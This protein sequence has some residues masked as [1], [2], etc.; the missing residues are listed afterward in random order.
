MYPATPSLTWP[1]KMYFGAQATCL[2]A[3]PCNKPFSAPDSDVLVCL[4]SLC[5]AYELALTLSSESYL[6]QNNKTIKTNL[7]PKLD[8][9]QYRPLWRVQLFLKANVINIAMGQNILL[10]I[11]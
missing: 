7:F 11:S 8:F 6:K 3:W 1:L 9:F 4:A 2:L 5:Q 10:K